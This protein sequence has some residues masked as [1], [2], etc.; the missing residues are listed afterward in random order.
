MD[1]QSPQG[2]CREEHEEGSEDNHTIITDGGCAN[3]TTFIDGSLNYEG[4]PTDGFPQIYVGDIEI[5]FE[6]VVA[7]QSSHKHEDEYLVA[8]NE[9]P[10]S[11]SPSPLELQEVDQIRKKEGEEVHSHD[12]SFIEGYLNSI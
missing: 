12:P 8:D 5:I 4:V 9:E 11:T 1:N 3:K 7:R 10:I 2:D 6:K